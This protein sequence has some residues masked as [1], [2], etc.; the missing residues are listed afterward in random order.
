MNT[1][2]LLALLKNPSSNIWVS[3]RKIGVADNSRCDIW[4]YSV[5]VPGIGDV[6]VRGL[7][8]NDIKSKLAHAAVVVDGRPMKLD[9]IKYLDLFGQLGYLFAVVQPNRIRENS[10]GK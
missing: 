4:E 8:T 6:V 1:D 10:I 3:G 9:N 7:E 2:T 5:R